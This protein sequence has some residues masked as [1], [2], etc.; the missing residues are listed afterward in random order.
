[1]NRYRNVALEP[2][3]GDEVKYPELGME[4]EPLWVI[5]RVNEHDVEIWSPERQEVLTTVVE[6]LTLIRPQDGWYYGLN[7]IDVAL[8][9]DRQCPVRSY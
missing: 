3:R 9:A 7:R 8:S 2:Q 1:M 4:P 5:R 6:N